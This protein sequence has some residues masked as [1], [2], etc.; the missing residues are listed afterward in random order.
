MRASI[1]LARKEL[2]ELARE[3]V[4]IVAFFV[5]LLLVVAI[6][7]VAFLYTSV[8]NP[9]VMQGY[10]SHQNVRVGVYGPSIEIAGLK[11]IPLE[12]ANISMKALNLVAV[13]YLPENF[14]KRLEKGEKVK[15]TLLLDNTNVLSGYADARISETLKAIDRNAKL[16]RAEELGVNRQELS[17]PVVFEVKG[18]SSS[19]RYPAEFIQ[20]MYGILIPFILLLPTF[21]AS[22][23]TTDLIVGEKER[24]TYELLVAAPISKREIILGKAM[25]IVFL[26]LGEAFLW[27]KIIELRGLPVYNEAMLLLY[28]LLLDVLFFVFGISI[29]AVSESVRDANSIV[30]LL[31]LGVSFIFF[32]PVAVKNSLQYLS[33]ASVIANLTS[34][35]EVTGITLPFI[36]AA[37]S[38]MLVIFIGEKLL[39]YKENLRV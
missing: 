9:E 20:L 35:P 2:N 17:S 25:P 3:K 24:R 13:L 26:S 39:V 18:A 32:A 29:S 1:A 14:E 11:V 27:I 12:K 21:V 8:S 6:I 4:Y 28:L 15:V 7:F 33:P 36:V 34:N 38:A 22:N 10:I 31:L 30:T 5:Q 19:G 23:M 16:K 37:L